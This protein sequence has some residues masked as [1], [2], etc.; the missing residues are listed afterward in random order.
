MHGKTDVF[1]HLKRITALF[2]SAVIVF[3]M[4]V[5]AGA[6]DYNSDYKSAT[7]SAPSEYV[8]VA[9]SDGLSIFANMSTGDFILAD[10]NG[11]SWHSTPSDILDDP[12]SK[13]ATMAQLKSL[14]SLTYI[15][16]EEVVSTSK[17]YSLNGY[18]AVSA[19]GVSVSKIK[20]GVRVEFTFEDFGFIVPIEYSLKSGYFSASIDV[21]NIKEGKDYKII[22]IELLPGFCT[23]SW[24]E[25]GYIFVPDGCGALINYNN[26]SE[27]KYS[28]M[29]YGEELAIEKEL[30][31]V[32][33]ET[34]RLPVFG[35][36][37]SNDAIFGIITEGD[38]SAVINA[39]S[40]NS[41]S[42]YNTVSATFV[43]RSITPKAMLTKSYAKQYAY[44]ISN[45]D[46]NLK[47][48]TVRYYPLSGENANYSGFAK[49]YRDYLATE[50]GLKKVAQNPSF[51][52]N[53]IG[54]VDFKANFLGFTYY[55]PA[56]LTTFDEAKIILESLKAD[57][58][59]DIS[60]RYEGW[61][62]DGLVN[63]NISTSA[64]AMRILGGK[65]D[66]EE[67]L[68]YSNDAGISLFTDADFIRYNGGSNKNA[69][70]TVFNEVAK[71]YSYMYSVYAP[72]LDTKSI[73][74]LSP[75]KIKN[76]AEKY[77][78]SYLKLDNTA[79]SLA[80]LTNTLYSELG[81]KNFAGRNDMTDIVENILES[82]VESGI[83]VS[84]DSANAYAVPYLSKIFN[85]P[86]NSSGFFVL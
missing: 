66:Y 45:A 34:I 69:T 73:K 9:E 31:S 10:T 41:N 35:T 56:A 81:K 22:Q 27:A 74:L 71:Q 18:S 49:T 12:Y 58:I 60:V 82:Y 62:N 59:K 84:G 37:S 85:T 63:R 51:N 65:N 78:E 83:A 79:I 19:G 47:K 36:A 44:R 76:T 6:S 14:I 67:L 5:S 7:V 48:F 57:G 33:K 11:N 64:K 20:D 2:V 46:K 15:N 54:S 26:G 24:K 86:A 72:R 38:G 52:I 16:T 68:S 75:S 8:L 77:L 40:S 53:L 29:V 32:N 55:K 80:S 21:Q 3:G 28:E 39:A 4:S 43:M 25:D 50:K 17:K 42:G 30:N 70:K 23:G 1:K 61:Q 13:A